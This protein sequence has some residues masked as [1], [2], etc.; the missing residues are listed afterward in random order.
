MARKYIDQGITLGL[1]TQEQIGRW[2]PKGKALR[3][4]G[5]TEAPV[6]PSNL[7]TMAC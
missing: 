5:K 1:W 4:R 3:H 6:R 7:A 2:F